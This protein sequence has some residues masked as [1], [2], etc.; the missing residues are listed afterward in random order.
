MPIGNIAGI[1]YSV[2]EINLDEMLESLNKALYEC[3]QNSFDNSLDFTTVSSSTMRKS[4]AV[5]DFLEEDADNAELDKF[6]G[7]PSRSCWMTI[8]RVAKRALIFRKVSVMQ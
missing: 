7:E 4:E 1:E 6:F 5:E 3:T 2:S 8:E